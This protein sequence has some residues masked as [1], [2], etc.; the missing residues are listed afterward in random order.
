MN[1]QLF[2]SRWAVVAVVF[3]KERRTKEIQ[4][5]QFPRWV[6]GRTVEVA[7]LINKKAGR[8]GLIKCHQKQAW[9]TLSMS[10]RVSD[11][12][13]PAARFEMP[14]NAPEVGCDVPKDYSSAALGSVSK[15]PAPIDWILVS[16][17]NCSDSLGESWRF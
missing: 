10:V 5:D 13:D 12:F 2:K 1:K 9:K 17:L 7:D 15:F 14:R 16:I 6:T 3:P 11:G 8:K 4:S